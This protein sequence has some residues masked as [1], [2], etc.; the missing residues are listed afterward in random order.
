MREKTFDLRIRYLARER[1]KRLT[2]ILSIIIVLVAGF[3]F[4][5][6]GAADTSVTDVFKAAYAGI[7]GKLNAGNREQNSIYK[8]I[9]LMRMPRVVMAI[10]AGIGLS[11]SGVSM[12]AVTRNPL[13]SPFTMG[14]SSAAA[15]GASM[16]IVF[17]KGVFFCSEIGIVSCAFL[18]SAICILFVYAVSSKTGMKAETVV[19]TGIAFNYFFSAL[20]SAIEF[21]A[22]EYKLAAVV[23]WS[24]GTFN[25]S[26]W[27]DVVF[28]GVV[29]AAG[30]AVI[31]FSARRLNI[32]SSGDD[33]QAEG[34]GINPKQTR[35]IICIVSVM[36][37]AAVISFTGVIGF[38]G[39]VAPHI[40][41]MVIGNDHRF[42]IPFSA[43]VGSLLLMA[44]DAVGRTIM[45]PV[46][47]P[48][49]IVVSFIGVP[50]F[51]NLILCERRSAL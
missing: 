18:A 38:I 1:K 47:I 35:G 41:R 3:Y 45:H 49:G 32:M 20:T 19:L 29:T 44:A 25:G 36:I 11:V 39:L 30:S 31:F 9:V 34:L 37:T 26:V 28:S 23:Q 7:L 5:G 14:I 15:F 17:G 6:V 13:V 50:I 40:A 4:I 21:F 2:V 43:S 33:E 22:Q 46:S 16:C 51:I 27:N 42:L 12:Q 24:F 48:V 8:I 10:I